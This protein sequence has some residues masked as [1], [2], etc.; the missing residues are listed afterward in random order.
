MYQSQDIFL[1]ISPEE[2]NRV[3]HLSGIFEKEIYTEDEADRLRECLNLMQQGKTDEE[4]IVSLPPVEVS[5]EDGNDKTSQITNPKPK[6]SKK[7]PNQEPKGIYELIAE[8][9]AQI[10]S[11]VT[12]TESLRILAVC[13]LPEQDE[14]STLRD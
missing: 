3:F 12:L 13:G 8:A 1:N 4:V 9:S 5:S 7:P 6:K 10:D 11:K 2:I 14:Y